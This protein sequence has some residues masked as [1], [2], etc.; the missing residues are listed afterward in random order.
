VDAPVAPPADGGAEAQ[1]DAGDGSSPLFYDDFDEPPSDPADAAALNAP[2][3]QVT[4][5]GAK[6]SRNGA[7]SFSPP[8]AML[9]QTVASAHEVDCAGY[10]S[11]PTA[12]TTGTYDLAFEIY[13]ETADTTASSDAVLTAFEL[14]DG[15]GTRW[16][17]QLEVSETAGTPTVDFSE[18]GTASDGGPLPFRDH[19][20]SAPLPIGAWTLVTMEVNV[21]DA[22]GPTASANTATLSFGSTVVATASLQVGTVN[23]TPEILVGVTYVQP[24][25]PAWT[26]RYDNVSLTYR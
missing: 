20:A 22:D 4:S 16:A 19:L 9:V 3:D 11:F 8:Y 13:V 26:V 6:A 10:K 1:V 24:A 12:A 17:L 5:L 14:L 21:T 2:W 15:A 23:G 7:V 25:S 18:N